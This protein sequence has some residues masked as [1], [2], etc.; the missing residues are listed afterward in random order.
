VDSAGLRVLASSREV[1]R[2]AGEQA[3]AVPALST[4]AAGQALD[5]DQLMRHDAVRLFVDRA[6]AALNRFQVDA[7]N[8]PAVAE[9][10]GRLDGL[11]L[12]IELVAARVRSL[13]V[14][15]IAE[16]LRASFALVATHDATVAPRQRTLQLLIDWS[17][18]LLSP[19]ERM[20]YRR[21]A[22]FAGGFDLDAA[23]Q[24][25]G[26]HGLPADQLLD[27]LGQLV[28]KSLVA[29]QWSADGALSRYRLLD[30][31][32]RH[33]DGQLAS[34]E[35][36]PA[37]AALR[38]SHAAWAMR[39]AEAARPHLAG[40]EQADWLARLDADRENLLAALAWC[41]RADH[42]VPDAARTAAECGLRLSFALRPYWINRGLAALGLA[43]TRA[44]LDRP[45]ARPRDAL[46][47]RGLFDAGQLCSFTGRYAEALQLLGESLAIARETG[48]TARQAAVLQPMGMAAL[49]LGDRAAARHYSQDAV[50]AAR[51]L[52]NPRQL[53]GACTALAQLDRMEGRLDAAEALYQE[54]MQ[55]ARALG[56]PEYVAIGLLNLAMVALGRGRADR[57]PPML[58]EVMAIA[59][60]NGSRPAA[61]CALDV[62]GA[63]AAQAGDWPRAARWWG[64]AEAHNRRTG[65]KRDAADEAFLAPL[66]RRL[67]AALGADA[68][69][70]A[71][72]AARQLPFEQPW[73][74]LRRWLQAPVATAPAPPTPPTPPK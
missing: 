47:A 70:L 38:R 34:A 66:L 5:A 54:F 44:V 10:C 68:L 67:Q 32:Q 25:C 29:V 16:R 33:A 73:E 45:G 19:A 2:V 65:L 28:E 11:P 14:A 40:P 53:A 30:T 74:E 57:V 37:L 64:L 55:L 71:E 59:D 24:V 72:L 20:L 22:L 26:D 3:F 63:L 61:L 41:T 8:A 6:S 17:H 36:A 50:D 39:L 9:I 69:A 31:V 12:A 58:L 7:A 15:A 23:E 60:A 62:G 42:A 27:L 21:L 1:L 49:G 46:R 13:P 4:P 18:D 51:A 35:P 52:D 56:D 48:D 43:A